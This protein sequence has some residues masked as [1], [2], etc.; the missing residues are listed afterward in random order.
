MTLQ[1]LRQLVTIADAGSMNEAA[2]QLDISQPNLS[3]TVKEAET[4]IG[5][6]IFLRMN[7][8]IRLTPEGEEFIGYARQVLN[9]YELLENKYLQKNS[10][11]K[12]SVSC[13]H[14]SFCVRAFAEMMGEVGMEE[15][16]FTIHE[17]TTREVI[18]DVRN[19]KSEIGIVCISEFNR[20]FLRK[21][22]R[23]S[24]V[25]FE[26][27]FECDTYVYLPKCHPLSGK[28]ILSAD[29][30]IS[31]PYLTFEQGPHS[32]FYM[33]EEKKNLYEYKKMIHCDDRAT[34]L[35]LM[36]ELNGYAFGSGIICEDL[37]GS[38]LITIPLRESEKVTIGYL[39]HKGVNSSRF[40]KIYLDKLREYAEKIP[41]KG[42]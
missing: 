37:N 33:T 6:P 38:D 32:I 2:K 41:K 26:P 35:N 39:H 36:T 34:M 22:F 42:L 30:L 14:L 10:R 20:A 13:R 12:F 28:D 15:Y 27:L 23:E 7:R 40:G 5:L 11:K 3:A 18:D 8:G 29:D 9:Q 25:V 19:M 16:E 31:Y 24:Q 17:T 21:A 1:H 4:E